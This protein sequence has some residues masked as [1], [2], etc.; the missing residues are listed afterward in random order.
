MH[1]ILSPQRRE[2]TLEISKN[3]DILIINGEAFDFSPMNEGDTLPAGATTCEWIIG[4]VHKE[5]GELKLKLILPLPVNFSPEQAFPEPLI[6]V[7]NGPVMFPQA[8][9][10]ETPFPVEADI[11]E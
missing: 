4:D 9:P 6:S 3:G 7:P 8:L 10:V 1:I 2:D 5:A 11:N